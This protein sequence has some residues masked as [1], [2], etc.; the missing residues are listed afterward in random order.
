MLICIGCWH[1]C[2]GVNF[3]F[4]ILY[5]STFIQSTFLLALGYRVEGCLLLY[6]VLHILSEYKCDDGD[7][8]TKVVD[9]VQRIIAELRKKRLM[10]NYRDVHN[11]V[12]GFLY[13]VPFDFSI[14]CVLELT[15]HMDLGISMTYYMCIWIC[16]FDVQSGDWMYMSMFI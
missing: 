8:A 10:E 4:E 12:I 11:F 9:F 13:G 7:H 3:A 16:K 2:R 1:L 15:E 5:L 6:F 14:Y